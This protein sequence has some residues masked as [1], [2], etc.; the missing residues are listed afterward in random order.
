MLAYLFRNPFGWD[1]VGNGLCNAAENR[2][3][4]INSRTLWRINNVHSFFD[5]I[6]S[7]WCMVVSFMPKSLNEF[8]FPHKNLLSCW[9]LKS[10]LRSLLS[11]ANVHTGDFTFI[12]GDAVQSY[13]AN[14][15]TVARNPRLA[16]LT[17]KY[18]LHVVPI[19]SK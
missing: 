11:L 17:P 8:L 18:C 2:L 4:K 9:L 3:L 16:Q 7:V 1:A 5:F 14:F 15:D 6:L 19:S 13:G 10:A 12:V